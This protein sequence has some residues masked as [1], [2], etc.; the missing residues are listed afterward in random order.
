MTTLVYDHINNIVAYDS[1]HIKD[2][3]IIIS[4]TLDKLKTIA[5]L[6]KPIF[7]YI[8]VIIEAA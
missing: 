4:D 3:G 6:C 8:P 7:I 1:R 2:E 5:M